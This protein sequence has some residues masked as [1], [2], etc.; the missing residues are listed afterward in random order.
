M[1]RLRTMLSSTVVL[2]SVTLALAQQ[3]AAPPPTATPAQSCEMQVTEQYQKLLADRVLQ[4]DPQTTAQPWHQ[5]LTTM[6]SQLRIVTTQFYDELQLRL[7]AGG[8]K[9]GFQEQ[10]RQLQQM[11]AQLVQEVD[12]LK[13]GAAPTTPPGQ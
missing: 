2:G 13:H 5:Q 7:Q 10:V 9:A 8:Q 11:N 4:L 1:P 3:P 12:K 6:I